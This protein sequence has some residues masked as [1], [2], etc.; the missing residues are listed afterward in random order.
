MRCQTY[1]DVLR[2]AI[3]L[4]CC[5]QAALGGL[6]N[7]TFETGNLAGWT[8]SGA[9]PGLLCDPAAVTR[10][11][12][13]DFL[14]PVAEDWLPT[15]GSY[16]AALWSTNGVDLGSTLGQS[17]TAEAGATLRFDYFFDFGDVAPFYDTATA[18]LTWSGGSVTLFEYNTAGHE[19]EDDENVGWTTLSCILPADDTYTLLFTLADYDGT[20]ESILGVDNVR[21]AVIPAPGAILLASIGA[22]LLPRLR[23]RRML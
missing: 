3:V 4:L 7:N 5:G 6:T 10:Q 13:R 22:G 23:R 1:G 2:I 18:T 15:E 21:L 17:F 11:L 20:F 14:A 19:L 9:G 16:F 12:S 8:S